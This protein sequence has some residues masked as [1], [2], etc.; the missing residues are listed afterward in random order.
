MKGEVLDNPLIPKP[1]G[2]SQYPGTVYSS[3]HVEELVPPL[4]EPYET[5]DKAWTHI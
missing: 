3:A 2:P 5:F 4:P 1:N